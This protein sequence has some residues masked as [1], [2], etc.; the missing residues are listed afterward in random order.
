MKFEQFILR[1]VQ[2]G[3]LFVAFLL[4]WSFAILPKTEMYNVAEKEAT[5]RIETRLDIKDS[6]LK[7]NMILFASVALVIKNNP[8]AMQRSVMFCAMISLFLLIVSIRI[9]QRQDDYPTLATILNGVK[10]VGSNILLFMMGILTRRVTNQLSVYF[11][12]A[13]TQRILVV[14]GYVLIFYSI[15]LLFTIKDPAPE[16]LP[17]IRLSYVWPL[18]PTSII[19]AMMFFPRLRRNYAQK[20]LWLSVLGLICYYFVSTMYGLQYGAK[21]AASG[22]PNYDLFPA[23]YMTDIFSSLMILI[24]L[25]FFF[26]VTRIALTS[27]SQIEAEVTVAQR[28]QQELIPRIDRTEQGIQIFGRS[29]SASFVGGDY[30]DTAILPDGRPV[31]TVADVSGHNLG[32]GLLMSMLKTAFHTELKYNPDPALLTASLNDTIYD[33]KNRKMF[34]SFIMAQPHPDSKELSLINA[35]HTPLIQIAAD[36]G[37]V[38]THWTRNL[39]LGLQRNA[40]YQTLRIAYKRGD[41]FVMYSD[42]L[43]EM[44]NATG[45]EW[46]SERLHHKLAEIHQKPVAEIY[47]E[48][49]ADASRFHVGDSFRDDVTLLLFRMP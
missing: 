34:I 26:E 2:F 37:A 3:L 10:N 46:G 49:V 33:T 21:I 40:E 14:I 22:Q 47:R 35:G 31:M 8:A 13:I 43:T 18:I 6:Q 9:N 15:T 24:A 12:L 29:E 7:K 28:I 19:T 30:I 42:G 48:L 39:A 41:L 45:E 38:S 23:F 20:M 1:I 11:N 32:A 27:K 5:R 36:T 25:S 4:L 16:M 44:T 17:L